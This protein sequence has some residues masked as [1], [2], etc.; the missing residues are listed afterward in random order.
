MGF[1][2]PKAQN[3]Q[4]TQQVTDLYTLF[5]C[6]KSQDIL[7]DNLETVLMVIQGIRNREKEIQMPPEQPETLPRWT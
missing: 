6:D 1:L 2:T 5:K 3:T 4:Q 7:A